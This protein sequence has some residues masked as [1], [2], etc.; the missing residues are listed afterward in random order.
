MRRVNQGLTLNIDDDTIISARRCWDE[1]E[2]EV[3]ELAI[4]GIGKPFVTLGICLTPVQASSLAWKLLHE[5][6]ISL[7]VI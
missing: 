2:Q 1:N 4:E 6:E 5:G 3:V 7:G